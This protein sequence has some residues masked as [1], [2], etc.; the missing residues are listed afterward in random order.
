MQEPAAALRLALDPMAA[1]LVDVGLVNGHA[2]MNV[3]LVRGG[4]WGS[5]GV[6]G[7]GCLWVGVGGWGCN[8]GCG[9]VRGLMEQNA[10]LAKQAWV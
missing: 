2:F 9:R 8:R 7:G 4:V 5:S 1:R 10:L 6:R 3:A